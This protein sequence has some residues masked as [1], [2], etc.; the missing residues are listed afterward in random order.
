MNTIYW[1]DIKFWSICIAIA[2]A[3]IASLCF[4][5]YYDH[6]QDPARYAAWCKLNGTNITYQ[7]W[8]TLKADHLL[9]GQAKNSTTVVP[10]V[11]P[12]R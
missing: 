6:K 7:E 11:V 2:G 12:T 8:L 3:L 5:A 1:E 9:P 10:I 4:V